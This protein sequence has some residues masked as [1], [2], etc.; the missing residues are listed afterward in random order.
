MIIL[1]PTF[2]QKKRSVQ[3]VQTYSYGVLHEFVIDF[4]QK[5]I[6]SDVCSF[7]QIQVT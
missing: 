6:P 2:Q 1:S 3:Y 7:N 5:K 4:E